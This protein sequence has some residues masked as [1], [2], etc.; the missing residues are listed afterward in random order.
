MPEATV[1]IDY[2]PKTGEHQIRGAWKIP[3]VK[4]KAVA[5]PMNKFAHKD[6]WLRILTANPSHV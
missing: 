1:N 2:P 5:E 3:P 4:A 6:F